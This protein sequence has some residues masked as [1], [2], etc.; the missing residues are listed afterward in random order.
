MHRAK[1]FL[2]LILTACSICGSRA[3]SS[4]PPNTT[5]QFSIGLW[6]PRSSDLHAPAI[7]DIQAYV[8]LRDFAPKV[9]DFINVQFFANSNLLGSSKAI[10]HD[11][12]RPHVPPGSAMPMWVQAAGFYPAKWHWTDVSAGSYSLTAQGTW[13]NGLVSV[14]VPL[15]ITVLPH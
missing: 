3:Q 4:F 6:V 10:W 5:N 11:E 8:H 15:N 2:F 12:I 14:C 1:A 9:G 7:V 13:T